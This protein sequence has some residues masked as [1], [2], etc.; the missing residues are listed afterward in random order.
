MIMPRTR[1][2]AAALVMLIAARPLAGFAQESI[3]AVTLTLQ[4]AA[5]TYVAGE[6]VPVKIKVLN[7]SGRRISF[8]ETGRPEVL[9]LEVTHRNSSTEIAPFAEMKIFDRGVTLNPGEMFTH[10]VSIDKVFDL[11]KN[12]DYLI[13]FSLLSQGR[14]YETKPA[15]FSVVPGKTV[16]KATQIFAGKADVQRVF[17]LV[18]WSRDSVQ[19]LFLRIEEVP[20]NPSL[21]FETI[22]L[23]SFIELA[24]E[25]RLDVAPNGEV[26]VLHRA[27]HDIFFKSVVWS[28]PK[29][30][31]YRGT[32]QMLDPVTAMS[33]RLK[34]VQDDVV[35]VMKESDK[36]RAEQKRKR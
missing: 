3:E 24:P 30:V 10:T 27:S 32:T 15:A 9:T 18:K 4:I 22:N 31:I 16:K 33:D 35:T 34:T 2:A 19:W 28:L 21:H 23:G 20:E 12:G 6:A 14:H 7:N 1:F 17:T 11:S 13:T 5:K 29:E 25:P 8:N 26:T 36:D